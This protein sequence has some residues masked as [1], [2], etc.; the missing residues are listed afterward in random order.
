MKIGKITASLICCS[1]LY[2]TSALAKQ[3][4]HNNKEFKNKKNLPYGL[5]KKL[6][7]G[8][9]LPSGWRTKLVKGKVLDQRILDQGIR[10]R[11]TEYGQISYRTPNTEVYKIQEKIIKV[12]KATNIILDILDL[13]K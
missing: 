4:K 1:L 11:D 12:N 3:N 6:K 13:N 8:G 10:L 7:R 9:Q 5:Q 2:G